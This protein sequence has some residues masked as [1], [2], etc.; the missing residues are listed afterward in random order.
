MSRSASLQAGVP[1][2]QALRILHVVETLEVGGLETMVVAMAAVQRQQGHDVQIVCLWREGALAEKARAA[3]VP[4]STI[5]KGPG[6]DWRSILRLRTKIREVRPDVLHTHNAMAHYYAVGAQLGLGLHC[7]ISTRHGNG[8]QSGADRIE[9][10]YKLAMHATH[11]GVAVSRAGQKRFL[12]TGV[13]PKAKARVV[14]NGIDLHGFISRTDER[15]TALRAELGLPPDVV[16]FGTVGRLNEVKRQVDLFEAARLRVDAGDR[17]AVVLVGDGPL[18]EELEQACDRLVL[19]DH[20]R[21]MGVR[22]DVPMLLAAMDVFV[23]SSRTEGYSLAL[24][25]AASAALPIIATD[26]GGNAEIVGEGVNG[27]IVPP[28]QPKVLSK[29]MATLYADAAMR[30]RYGAAGREWAMREGTLET[31]CAAYERLYL[32]AEKV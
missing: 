13:I 23:L 32:H 6:L 2:G 12:E 3:G 19:R 1:Q 28:S 18:R 17:I 10:L 21:F 26:V 8:A 30:Q 7:V 4:V 24:V 14:P 25:E 31:M 29:A 5:N 27:L 9:Q 11:Y 22:K 15:A 20:V 16:T